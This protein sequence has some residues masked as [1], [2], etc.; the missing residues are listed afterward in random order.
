MLQRI[1]Q[2]IHNSLTVKARA[3]GHLAVGTVNVSY[4]QVTATKQNIQCTPQTE[5]NRV[6]SIETDSHCLLSMQINNVFTIA[7]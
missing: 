5:A 4:C 7:A 1:N 2:I 3:A 6:F